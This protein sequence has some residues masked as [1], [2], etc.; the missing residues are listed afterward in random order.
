MTRHLVWLV[1]AVSVLFNLGFAAS[2]LRARSA[3]T[4][5]ESTLEQPAS[6]DDRPRVDEGRRGPRGERDG[7]ARLRS[8][9]RLLDLDEEQVAYFRGLHE[10]LAEDEAVFG[11]AIAA[12]REALAEA[13]RGDAPA[14]DRLRSLHEREAELLRQRQL[15]R[16]ERFE[17]F[18]AALRPDQIERF[19][20]VLQ[21]QT[22]REDRPEARERIAEVDADGD[23]LLDDAEIAALRGRI[24]ERIRQRTEMMFQRQR[25][26]LDRFDTNGD[27]RLDRA[28]RE[29]AMQAEMVRRHDRDGDG[30]LDAAEEEAMQ[31]EREAARQRWERMIGPRRGEGRGGPPEGPGGAG[32]PGTPD[33]PDRP[34]GPGRRF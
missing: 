5:P 1:L 14:M 25:E 32:G 20:G 28:E 27:G 18:M 8:A 12:L 13:Y 9:A 22:R 15:A 7:E 34:D 24:S 6:A 33:D 21:E 19:R 11:T 17:A 4:P 30:R 31:A 2:Y 29:A 10:G 23:G 3:P 26:A 16:S